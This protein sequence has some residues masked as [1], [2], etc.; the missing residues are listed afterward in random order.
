M[1]KRKGV[2]FCSHHER[3]KQRRNPATQILSFRKTSLL[4]NMKDLGTLIWSQAF[5]QQ[6]PGLELRLLDMKLSFECL[7]FILYH[8]TEDDNLKVQVVTKLC[9]NLPLILITSGSKWRVSGI[10][11]MP[12]EWLPPLPP[13][14]MLLLQRCIAVGVLETSRKSTFLFLIVF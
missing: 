5:L 7:L 10:E 11:Q 1:F 4:L 3:M 6:A 14:C 2:Y 9:R 12:G 13:P 8:G